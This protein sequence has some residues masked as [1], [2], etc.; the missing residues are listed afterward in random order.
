MPET[1]LLVG[2][3]VM[4]RGYVEAARALGLRIVLID[5]PE[6][7]ETYAGLVDVFLSPEGNTEADWLAAALRAAEEH[8]P[9]G[10]VP[11]TEIHVQGAAW[12]QDLLG[13]PGPSLAATDTSRNKSVQRVLFARAGITQPEFTV[14]ATAEHALRWS[15]DRYPVVVKPLR[16]MGSVGV[17][18]VKNAAELTADLARR[19][20]AEQ[21]LVEQY[22][23]FPEYSW[24]GLVRD[25]EVIFG[26]YTRK[27]TSGPPEFV[28]LRHEVAWCDLD[29]ERLDP[30]T[31][32]VT[33]ALGVRTGLVHL[34]FRDDGSVAYPMEL[35][36]R[37]PGDHIMEL[38]C[39]AYD[40]DFFASHIELALGRTPLVPASAARS[41]G[42]VYVA[43]AR[44]GRIEAVH[45]VTDAEQ[46]PG[47]VRVGH[48]KKVGDLVDGLRSSAD[49][50]SHALL[51][52]PDSAALN[53][54]MDEVA[55]LIDIRTSDPAAPAIVLCKWRAEMV[56]ALLAIT[57]NLHL[58]V[59]AADVK[60]ADYDESL[61]GEGG[62]IYRIGDFDSVEELT[63]VAVDLKVRGID[64]GHVFTFSEGSQ[65]G[66]NLLRDLL[67]CSGQD[68][69]TLA[70]SRD[71]RMM[72][73]LVGRVGVPVARWASLVPGSFDHVGFPSVVKPAF[74]FGTMNT[75]RVDSAQELAEVVA[76][77]PDLPKLRSDHL[78][79]EEFVEG[80]ELHIDAL[81]SG[82]AP[83][84]FT[85]S[86]YYV[87]RLEH[88]NGA[89]DTRDGSY[90]LQRDDHPELYER[91][92]AL[93]NE[94]NRA[95]GIENAITHLEVFHTAADEIVFSEVATRMGGGWV[96]DML[97]AHLGQDVFAV[98]ATGLLRGEI[99]EPKPSHR[100][101]GALHLRP[102]AAGTVVG[103]PTDDEIRAVDGVVSWRRM[104]NVGDSVGFAD[105]MDW[106]LLVVLGADTEDGFWRLADEVESRLAITVS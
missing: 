55:R 16:G 102:V 94:V 103:I 101:L 74:G 39:R 52:A 60:R 6:Y 95:L 42:V 88:M 3:G 26:N 57:S 89:Q 82:G 12:A 10:V 75:V 9:D 48:K 69:L 54:E 7:R 43:A 104:K 46:C 83:L 11:F 81:W 33:A 13:L 1:V 61:L 72:K 77:L 21:V 51:T 35:A 28:E 34:E 5:P 91:L 45:G 62:R 38:M 24:E 44:P 49:R 50:V 68:Q 66:T 36:V 65:L 86:S 92:F 47:V 53:A 73:E 100:Y 40:H 32:Q 85:V 2:A 97:S 93:H 79:V 70:A 25:G 96:P 14:A 58:V 71:K 59:D 4:G 99:V 37:M 80:R 20:V 8:R 78:I 76:A 98:L 56:P 63:G 22:V 64:V 29:L 19:D 18:L 106:C 84:F 27:V 105:T 67:G 15:E 87:P 41:A 31:A 90:I 23:E 30:W 17:R